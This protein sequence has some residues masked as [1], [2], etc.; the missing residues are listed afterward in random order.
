MNRVQTRVLEAVGQPAQQ[1]VVKDL[2]E[3]QKEILNVVN[4]MF[5]VRC[6]VLLAH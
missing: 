3:S 6:V 2:L 1:D 5:E 4:R